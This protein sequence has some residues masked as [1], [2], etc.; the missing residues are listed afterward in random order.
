MSRD[1]AWCIPCCSQ[2]G[3]GCAII[4]SLRFDE[5]EVGE[6]EQHGITPTVTQ[7]AEED[8]MEEESLG[9]LISKLLASSFRVPQTELFFLPFSGPKLCFHGCYSN[10]LSSRINLLSALY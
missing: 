9:D 3:H 7:R 6:K 1:T 8:V 5:H 4:A 2:G 10:L